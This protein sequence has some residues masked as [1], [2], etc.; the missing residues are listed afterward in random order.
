MPQLPPAFKLALPPLLLTATACHCRVDPE[1][2][3]VGAI[4]DLVSAEAE[5]GHAGR[6]WASCGNGVMDLGEN[7]LNCR[8]DVDQPHRVALENDQGTP[9][10]SINGARAPLLGMYVYNPR[11]VEGYISPQADAWPGFMQSQVEKAAAHGLTYVSLKAGLKETWIGPEFPS[12]AQ[13]KN[14]DN[15][16]FAQLDEVMDQALAQGVYVM[17]TV[18]ASMPPDWWK[19]KHDDAIQEDGEGAK[20]TLVSFH[21][22]DYWALTDSLMP[23]VIDHFKQHPALLGWNVRIGVTGENNY[24]PN[25]TKDIFDPPKTWCDYSP[26]AQQRFRDWLKERYG[27]DQALQQAWCNRKASISR[28]E[29]PRPLDT[30][31]EEDT[32]RV[33]ELL[34]GPGDDRREFHDWM[35]FRLDE[36][37]ADAQHFLELFGSRDPEHLVLGAP[38]FSPLTGGS[39]PRTGQHDGDTW[40][41]SP[42]MGAIL[43]HP[44]IAHTDKK[45]AFNK[46]RVDLLLA[47]VHALHHGKLAS[48]ANEETSEVVAKADQENIW[49][50][51]AIA[52]MHAS[53]GHG[54]GWI[55]GRDHEMIPAWSDSE[56]A[57]I[58]LRSAIYSPPGLEAPSPDVALLT[59]PFSEG[60]QYCVGGRK[61]Y[62]H[63][64]LSDRSAFV[65]SLVRNGLQFDTLTTD[66]LA[67]DPQVLQ[68]YK[69]VLVLNIPRLPQSAAQALAAWRDEG[70]GLFVGGRT[71]VFDAYGDEDDSAL[72][73]LLGAQLGSPF[74]RR[75]D[76]W[77]F[78]TAQ[79]PADGLSGVAYG[80]ANLYR[81]PQIKG[82]G[83]VSLAALDRAQVS[84]VGVKGKTVYWFPKLCSRG[85]QAMEQLAQ[86]QQNLWRFFGAQA[87]ASSSRV[88]SF[89]VYGASHKAL[90]TSQAQTVELAFDGASQHGA[91]V[92]DWLSM[93][94]VGLIEKGGSSISLQSQVEQTWYLNA[95]PLGDE[96]AFVAV[97]GAQAG[98]VSWDGDKLA[99]GL[100]RAKPGQPIA[101]AVYPGRKA[102]RDFQAT[103]ASV[104][105]V[106]KDATG[107]A[108][109]VELQPSDERV[110]LTL[111]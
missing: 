31:D 78:S 2:P 69:A 84:T 93:Q 20:W 92:W 94:G 72:E 105:R 27:S 85:A 103:G 26:H 25:Y 37:S 36:K 4:S 32:R 34:N 70:G 64:L 49:R 29:L 3:V 47:D 23:H 56:F 79:A 22:T 30:V 8:Q 95:T 43:H 48:W 19:K 87:V 13:A 110:V 60:F 86:F 111:E 35:R 83:Y 101:L 62:Q 21:D 88:G 11:N 100:Y 108:Q 73:A 59:D 38:A 7:L 14:P 40:Y 102:G 39:N 12:D 53:M 24:G 17:L 109:V 89:E 71:G 98:P 6:P 67:A 61:A 75:A 51:D 76:Q 10:L 97:Q 65:Q 63:G 82:A 41:A 57:R 28:A 81:I 52:A 55:S 90:F 33:I 16:D 54:D 44:R 104:E 96:P 107:K 42:H 50:L 91:L 80:K 15:W 106:E 68:R 1:L 18:N 45:G 5:S 46:S 9:W 74:D 58:R 77:S 66:D 99:I